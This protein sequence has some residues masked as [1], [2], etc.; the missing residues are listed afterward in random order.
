MRRQEEPGRR[1][2]AGARH[3]RCRAGGGRRSRTSP[4][5]CA[6]RAA[7]NPRSASCFRSSVRAS[8]TTL[9]VSSGAKPRAEEL[10][11]D[12]FVQMY[13]FR[14]RY[15]PESRLATWVYKIATNVVPERAPAA[16]AP[17]AHRSLGPE[18]A[19]RAARGPVAPRSHAPT[20][21]QGASTRELSKRL[22][23]AGRPCLRSSARALLSPASTGSRIG[24]WR[25]RSAVRRGP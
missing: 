16:R 21:E 22:E 25:A 17:A 3:A 2:G 24:T 6:S 8:C 10:T 19:R 12:V 4:S 15:R 11:Q 20:A 1:A 23:S 5:C 18:R 9:A 13:R 7:T 14:H